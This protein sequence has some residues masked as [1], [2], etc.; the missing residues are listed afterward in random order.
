MALLAGAGPTFDCENGSS[1]QQE[2]HGK[3][4]RKKYAALL[5]ITMALGAAGGAIGFCVV[6]P[7][8]T[9]H[10]TASDG[11]MAASRGHGLGKAMAKA[12]VADIAKNVDDL[13]DNQVALL[14]SDL[15]R[16]MCD[17]SMMP[18]VMAMLKDPKTRAQLDAILANPSFPQEMTNIAE[19]SLEKGTLTPLK[20]LGKFNTVL[21]T[22]S[23]AIRSQ[24]ASTNTR[25]SQV[26]AAADEPS[27]QA[28]TI[29]AAAVGGLAGIQ[30][31][32]ELTPAL[33]LCLL[34][35]YGTT[36]TG[37]FGNAVKSVGRIS[38]KAWNKGTELNEQYELLPKGKTALDT[39][40]RTASNLNA[41]YGITEK[42][43]QKLLLSSKID[44]VNDK[45]SDFKNKVSDKVTE[46]GDKATTSKE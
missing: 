35:A 26:R 23:R 13:N 15:Q 16:D 18:E 30:L 40:L 28:V 22:G 12:Y 31:F 7:A 8:V 39:T 4:Q 5:L 32:G 10:G 42:I 46:L 41:N 33:G 37:D 14:F 17:D 2:G 45:I 1:P 11:L 29:A 43:D 27:D 9:D 38:A 34:A 24:Y 25:V 36:K 3:A 21:P 44:K 20:A 6:G 19:E